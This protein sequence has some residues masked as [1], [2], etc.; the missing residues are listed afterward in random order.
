M[1]LTI[2]DGS[3]VSGADSFTTDVEF[4][5]WATARGYTLPATEAERDVLQIKAMDYLFSIEPRMK[6]TRASDTQELPYPRY[7]VDEN[8]FVLA[9]NVIPEGLKKAQMA[10]AY[11]VNT[12]DLLPNEAVSNLASFDVKGVYSES[13]GS[14]GASITVIPREALGYLKQLLKPRGKSIRA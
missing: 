13:Y 3:I 4:Q 12:Q 7:G 11:Y 8:G 1:A 10:L 14:G 9:S 5:A 6:G 2:E